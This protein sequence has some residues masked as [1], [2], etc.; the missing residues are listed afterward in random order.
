[1]PD[2][3]IVLV[4]IAV[5]IA[6]IAGLLFLATMSLVAMIAA[7]SSDYELELF[8]TEESEEKIEREK[9]D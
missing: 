5:A 7:A 6:F 1:M 8:E 9:K 3:V 2:I 4:L